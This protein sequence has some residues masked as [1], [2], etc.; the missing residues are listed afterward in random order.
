MMFLI[1][2]VISITSYCYPLPWLLL[3]PIEHYCYPLLWLLLSFTNSYHHLRPF[4]FIHE[5]STVTH[6]V[7]HL[8]CG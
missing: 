6:T 7:I 3:S 2:T 4:V 5:K 1:I 8:F